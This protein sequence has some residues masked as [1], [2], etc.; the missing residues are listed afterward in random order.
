VY[1]TSESFSQS[2]IPFFGSIPIIGYL[3]KNSS[4][5]REQNEML[6]FITPRIVPIETK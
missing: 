3:F 1:A 4:K 2:R 6:V 5:S